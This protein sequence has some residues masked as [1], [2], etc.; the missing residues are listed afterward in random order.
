MPVDTHE[1]IMPAAGIEGPNVVETHEDIQPAMGVT[2][3]HGSPHEFEQFDTSKIGTG[4]GAQA[5]GHGL[6]FAE[7]EPVAKAYR[8]KLGM[9]SVEI[10]GRPAADLASESY[11]LPY[12]QQ[13]SLEHKIADII[14]SYGDNA[15]PVM[16]ARYPELLKAYDELKASGNIKEPGSMYEVNLDV[17][18]EHLLDWDKPLSEQPAYQAVRQHWDD[19]VGDPDIILKRLD[20]GDDSTGRDLYEALGGGRRNPENAS[21][22]L[23]EMGIRGIR[24]LDAGSRGK[25][26]ESGSHNYV[27]FDPQH[28]KVKR[29]YAEGGGV[30]AYFMHAP[31][32]LLDR[33]QRAYGGAIA[34]PKLTEENAE[35]FA[36]RLILWSYAAAPFVN[37]SIH[38]ATGGEVDPSVDQALDAARGASQADP[39]ASAMET[40]RSLTPMGFYSAAAEAASKIPQRAPVDQILNKVKGAPGVKAEELDWSGVK[41]AFAGQRSV[42]P[43]EVARHFQANLPALQ[44][45]VYKEDDP[46]AAVNQF[47][48]EEL[49]DR[50]G[51]NYRE[52]L[53]HLPYVAAE[54][55]NKVADFARSMREKYGDRWIGK[56]S[57]EEDNLY[58]SL[59][60][61]HEK[62]EGSGTT[63]NSSHYQSVPNIVAHL[64]MSDRGTYGFGDPEALHLE[65]V[66][67]DWGQDMRDG[68]EVPEGPHIGSSEGWTDLALKRALRE[69]AN[70]KYKKL[71]WS[72]GDD[73]INR[74]NLTKHVKHI[75][76]SPDNQILSALTHGGGEAI[77][78]KVNRE[79]LPKYIGKEAAQKLLDQEPEI[80]GNM[81]T[82]HLRGQDLA[83]GGEGMKSFYDRFLPGRLQKLVGK[84]DPE[85]K[86][87]LRGHKMFVPDEEEG[88]SDEGEYKSVHSLEITPK[89]RAAIL[90]G[91]PAYKQGGFA[92]NSASIVNKALDVVSGLR[93]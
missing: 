88:D 80:E 59:L 22:A 89:L 44:E 62:A 70:G 91:L 52:V 30:K 11:N 21:K 2:A 43:Q 92:T 39:A 83:V 93:R 29:R 74:Y 7:S 32:D 23:S 40:A 14:S 76:W 34:G 36:R 45:T 66:Q 63:Y 19:K 16:E 86:V 25:D 79:D 71:T 4:E 51:R 18:P 5:Y 17:G 46:E 56:L 1:D 60:S 10:N 64:R 3:Y 42:D 58:D 37:R 50:G 87:Q 31:Q 12:G 53:L 54:E 47:S 49:K 26:G 38:R 41:D 57:Q 35:D 77:G 72:T 69:A 20:I 13:P 65:E 33:A 6:Y 81:A 55:S 24:Y 9:G 78:K 84:L 27:I 15:R 61:L 8:D 28:I 90:K 85:A 75:M 73:Q 67:S 82:H 48:H 68:R